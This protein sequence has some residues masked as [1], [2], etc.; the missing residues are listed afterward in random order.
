MLH[1]NDLYN[2]KAI[3]VT[4]C[5][6]CGIYP[7]VRILVLLIPSCVHCNFWVNRISG[8]CVSVCYSNRF[9]ILID[10]TDESHHDKYAISVLVQYRSP[11]MLC[12]LLYMGS[13]SCILNTAFSKQ[14]LPTLFYSILF[15]SI[16]FYSILFFICIL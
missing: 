1:L 15:Y 11:W 5:I 16:L 4:S 12:I 10:N 3:Y 7:R 8:T 13:L 6:F 9:C 14:W 2:S